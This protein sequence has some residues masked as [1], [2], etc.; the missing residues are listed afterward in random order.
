MLKENMA[1]F[2]EKAAADQVL[3]EKLAEL[4][5]QYIE[6]IIALAGENGFELAPEE[7]TEAIQPLGDEAMESAAG[8]WSP[9][10]WGS[11]CTIH[12]CK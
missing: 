11:Y 12:G 1:R 9:S 7:F 5:K 3:T 10:P 2:L 4:Q 8:G 6:Q